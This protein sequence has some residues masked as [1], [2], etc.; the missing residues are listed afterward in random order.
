M[1]EGQFPLWAFLVLYD[2]LP[3]AP[4]DTITK[5][6]S[7]LVHWLPRLDTQESCSMY[8]PRKLGRLEQA[9]ALQE[10]ANKVLNIHQS[11]LLDYYRYGYKI[12]TA[13]LFQ[14]NAISKLPQKVPTN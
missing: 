5:Q 3:N 9:F 1:S 12:K 7:F 13:K 14:Q 11:Q 4:S 8:T 10:L 2:S 6:A